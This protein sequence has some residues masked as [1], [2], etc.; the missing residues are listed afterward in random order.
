[1]EKLGKHSP[2]LKEF[3]RRV[4]DRRP[5]EVIVDGKR[6]ATDLVRW[7]VPI[8]E[9]YLAE[10]TAVDGALLDAADRSWELAASVFASIAPT[11]SPQG[12]LVVVGEPEHEHWA[13]RD[14]LA[15]YLD[16]IQDPGN[17]GAIVRAAAGLGA[18]GV[19]LSSGCADPFGWATVR[20]SAGAV[21]RLPVE[22]A[23]ES[24]EV[25]ERVR[26]HGGEVWATA[27]RGGRAVG[28]WRPRNPTLLLLGGEGRGLNQ[29][30][31]TLADG[32]VAIDLDRDIDSLNV[33][34]AAGILLHHLRSV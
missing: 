2:R 4:R 27:S 1:M 20:A 31:L 33:A 9:L 23:A 13:A 16:R 22:R 18:G 7:G 11:K 14:G 12:V 17:V 25:A 8:H 19:M 3:R 24:V 28:A 26:D 29:E 10:G 21:M 5:G 15:L 32:I 6:L 34:V 30:V